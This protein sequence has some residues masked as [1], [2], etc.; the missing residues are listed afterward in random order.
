[1]NRLGNEV[2]DTCTRTYPVS[3]PLGTQLGSKN[4]VYPLVGRNGSDD[5]QDSVKYL[6]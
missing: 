6:N 2:D 3:F 5:P 1:V 4:L